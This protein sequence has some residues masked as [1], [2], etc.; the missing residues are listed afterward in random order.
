MRIHILEDNLPT[1]I[2]NASTGEAREVEGGGSP[3]KVVSTGKA[4]L[5]PSKEHM[6]N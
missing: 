4:V 5:R 6:L 2:T 1:S 3:D